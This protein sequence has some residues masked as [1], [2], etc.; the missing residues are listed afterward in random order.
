MLSAYAR[1]A[2][3]HAQVTAVFHRFAALVEQCLRS[4]RVT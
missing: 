2:H 4:I 1:K 3:A